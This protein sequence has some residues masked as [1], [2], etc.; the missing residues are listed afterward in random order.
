MESG[1]G[2]ESGGREW[3]ER[4]LRALEFY[5]TAEPRNELSAAGESCKR[6]REVSFGSACFA[7]MK[8]FP[9]SSCPLGLLVILPAGSEPRSPE[10][11]LHTL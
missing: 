9:R 3:K 4:E 6:D 7:P 10:R 1:K 5:R 2:R 8:S 11:V